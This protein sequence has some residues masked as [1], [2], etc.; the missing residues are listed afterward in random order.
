MILKVLN[1]LGIIFQVEEVEVVEDLV[2]VEIMEDSVGEVEVVVDLEEA[3]HQ[4]LMAH[5]MPAE[6]VAEEGVVEMTVILLA[7][8]EI[9]GEVDLDLVVM[10]VMPRK[11]AM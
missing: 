1:Y 7:A 4:I 5:Q 2:G 11:K 8:L 3:D 9:S 6:V 10:A